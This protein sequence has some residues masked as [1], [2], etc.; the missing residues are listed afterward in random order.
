MEH[1]QSTAVASGEVRDFVVGGNPLVEN[2]VT[3]PEDNMTDSLPYWR[4][5]G[6]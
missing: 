1:H 4:E 2:N 5:P 6:V 3:G